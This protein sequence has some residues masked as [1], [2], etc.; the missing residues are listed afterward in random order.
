MDGEED[1]GGSPLDMFILSQDSLFGTKADQVIPSG[2]GWSARPS[3]R[4]G[5]SG[6]MSAASVSSWVTGSTHRARQAER[7]ELLLLLRRGVPPCLRCAV[8]VTNVVAAVSPDMPKHEV[9]EMGTLRKVQVLE[10]GWKVALRSIF[11]DATDEEDAHFPDFG[12]GDRNMVNLLLTGGPRGVSI[13]EKGAKA[14]KRVLYAARMSLGIEYCPILPDMTAIC[15]TAMDEA[16]AYATIR[17]MLEDS[18]HFFPLSRTEHVALC[19]T[20]GDLM[21]KLYP[22]THAIMQSIGMLTPGAL[23]PIFKRFFVTILRTEH[24]KRIMDLYT[25][26]GLDTLFRF[27]TALMC[28]YHAH[29][30]TRTEL[31]CP[32]VHAWWD[33]VRHFAHSRRFKFDVFLSDQVYGVVSGTLRQRS[34]F[35]RRDVV[36][37]LMERNEELAESGRLDLTDDDLVAYVYNDNTLG[38]VEGEVPVVLAKHAAERHSLANW[39]PTSLSSTKLECIYSSNVHGRTIERF[40]HHVAKTK[41]S[42]TL[43]EV[44]G[45]DVTIGMFATQTWHS[46]RDGYGDGNW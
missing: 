25:L 18:S 26:E 35:P 46:N 4:E 9:D 36:E 37:R 13:P 42:I 16:Y 20:F 31:N 45:K 32:D 17:Q 2:S 1:A 7:E 19:K 12:L 38:F 24:V 33:G 23:D 6:L 40:Y 10:H 11:P 8:W 30:T 15:L 39:L 44:L 3:R 34:I 21:L 5:G 28:L 22:Q 27:G 14:L 43:L 41:H 29:L